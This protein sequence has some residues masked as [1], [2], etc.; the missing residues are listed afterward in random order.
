MPDHSKMLWLCLRFDQ[1]PLQALQRQHSERADA[2]SIVV[3]VEKQRVLQGNQA[4]SAR[5]IQAGQKQ[6]TVRALAADSQILERDPAQE[7]RALIRLCC[8]AYSISP[9]LSCYREDALLLE[10]GGCLKLFGGLHRLLNRI[11]MDLSSR[12][13]QYRAGLASTPRGAWLLSHKA[14]IG[15]PSGDLRRDVGPLPLALLTD[16][17]RQVTSL[18]KAGMYRFDDILDLHPATLGRRCGKEF[19]LFLQQLTGERPD[20]VVNY[21]PP[22]EFEDEY[23]FGFDVKDKQE[24]MPAMRVLLQ[25][26]CQFLLARQLVCAH[27]K[28]VFYGVNRHTQVLTINCSEAHAD[29]RSWYRL[30]SI[31]L[32]RFELEQSV[33]GLALTCPSLSAATAS[34]GEL[35]A[36]H[37]NRE[38]LHGI[39]DRLQSRLGRKAVSRLAYRDEHV[40]ELAGTVTNINQRQDSHC[41]AEGICSERNRPFWLMPEPEPLR[42]WRDRLFWRG[43]LDLLQGPERIEDNWWSEPVSRD[44]YVAANPSGERYWIYLDRLRSGWFIHG[45]FA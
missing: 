22:P 38:P 24:L 43:P 31:K 16:F 8:W 40:P 27:L 26:L 45:I 1:L 7:Q 35:F 6:A 14:D 17:P 19:V 28:W 33:E 18:G 39:T 32:E 36:V 5:G 11:N 44:Y 10:I 29:W 3:V 9:R 23:L 15:L 30:L 21:L 37:G 13:W 34:S 42:Q 2:E 12:A 25:S 4:A 20:D 41:I